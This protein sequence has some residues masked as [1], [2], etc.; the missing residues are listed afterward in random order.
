MANLNE[1]RLIGNLTATPELRAAGD[2]DV[3]TVI[4]ATDTFYGRGENRQ[5]ETEYSRVVLWGQLA[6][7][8]STY[9]Q[10]G[11][12][13]FVS[14]RLRTRKWQDTSGAEHYTTEVIADQ[15]Q[16]LGGRRNGRDADGD[17]G[18]GDEAGSTDFDA[19]PADT[20]KGGKRGARRT[21]SQD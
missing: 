20:G 10:K 18:A 14:G 16:Q 19:A 3:S 17:N 7:F 21:R 8:A 12:E 1:V 9:L 5:K 4:V 6:R 2:N 13:V 15:I 11:N